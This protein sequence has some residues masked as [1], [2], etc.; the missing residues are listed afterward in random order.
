[1]DDVLRILSA[2]FEDED[3]EQAEESVP[4]AETEVDAEGVA[5]GQEADPT[6]ADDEKMND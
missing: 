4:E 1:M 5:E 2:E 3:S 6:A